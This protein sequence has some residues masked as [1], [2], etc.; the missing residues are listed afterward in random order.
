MRPEN[1][2]SK[3]TAL[4]EPKAA[5]KMVSEKRRHKRFARPRTMAYS[6]FSTQHWM[7]VH[8]KSVNLSQKGIGFVVKQPLALNTVV[9][10]RSVSSQGI[11]NH[12]VQGPHIPYRVMAEVRWCRKLFSSDGPLYTIGARY[13]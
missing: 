11:E 2:C 3:T 13:L 10:I 1:C 7:E 6:I 5:T 9:C 12:E 4:D 8:T